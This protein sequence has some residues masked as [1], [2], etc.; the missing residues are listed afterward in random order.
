MLGE[1]CVPSKMVEKAFFRV[2]VTL[3]LAENTVGGDKKI[4]NR[5]QKTSSLNKKWIN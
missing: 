5:K 2:S 4:I 1:K 3:Y